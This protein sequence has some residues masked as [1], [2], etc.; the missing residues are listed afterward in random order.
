MTRNARRIALAWSPEHIRERFWSKV[1]KIDDDNSCWLWKGT[2]RK[3]G[4]GQFSIGNPHFGGRTILAHRMAYEL[5]VAPIAPGEQ[6]NHHCDNP[7]CCRPSHLYAGNAQDNMDDIM[8]RGRAVRYDRSGSSN[9]RARLTEAE[10]LEI[11]RR[12]NQGDTRSALAAAFGISRGALDHITSGRHWKHLPI[13][14][15]AKEAP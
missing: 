5:A 12:Y 3:N 6:I 4:Y 15:L 13:D 1:A 9:P 14:G 10:V 8:A 7:P 2:I 11:R